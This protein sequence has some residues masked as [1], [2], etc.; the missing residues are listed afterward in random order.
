MTESQGQG[1]PP[2]S[3]SWY[4]NSPYTG[5]P[6][7]GQPGAGQAAA[8]QGPNQLPPGLRWQPVDYTALSAQSS[9]Q[10]RP[11]VVQ[12]ATPVLGPLVVTCGL[13]LLVLSLATLT[14]FSAGFFATDFASL[15]AGSDLFDGPWFLT[16]YFSW[17]GIT[18]LLVSVVAAYA[19]TVFRPAP[20]WLRGAA[21]VV[22]LGGAVATFFAP[23]D[24]NSLHSV[25]SSSDAGYWCM[26]FGFV[27]VGLGALVRA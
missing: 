16:T 11:V 17:L 2:Q 26:I 9:E 13:V 4:G 1:T 6:V 19:T 7:G 21:F 22:A 27:L 23:T 24:G 12:P 15:H 20:A 5:Q 8:P 14:W 18:L 10:P 3:T 25:M